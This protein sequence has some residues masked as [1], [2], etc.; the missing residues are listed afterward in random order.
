MTVPR[1]KLLGA[2]GLLCLLV[3]VA[4]ISF[5]RRQ[6]AGPATELLPYQGWVR[7]LP[8]AEQERFA[9]VGAAIREAE[10]VRARTHQWPATFSPPGLGWV[11]RGQGLYVNYLGVPAERGRLRWLVLLIEP[12]PTAIKDRPPPDDE[13][14]HTLGDGT[15]IHVSVWTAENEGP[16]P[17]VILP[18]PA[19]ESWTQRLA[20]PGP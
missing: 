3:A 17:E 18:F 10:Q 15:A 2:L 1:S 12:E 19:A 5:K 13:E 7:E 9:Q 8:A 11:Q 16:V 6:K 20:G 14:H 4:V